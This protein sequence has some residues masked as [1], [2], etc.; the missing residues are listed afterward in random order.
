MNQE[1]LIYSIGHSSLSIEQFLQ[2]LKR[3]QIR[4]LVDV[5]RFPSSK[6]YP[7]FDRTILN[8]ELQQA[9]IEYHSLGDSLGGFRDEGYQAHMQTDLFSQGLHQL[10]AVATQHQTVFMC[11][12]KL[13]LRCHRRFI[14][15]HLANHAWT[16][17]HILDDSRVYP[18]QYTDTLPFD[19]TN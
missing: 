6:K 16:V 4:A 7:Q 17:I 8:Q 2:L 13:F 15:D 10:I 1:R 14:S 19:F 5:R 18:H 12:E 9:N 3:F 11:A